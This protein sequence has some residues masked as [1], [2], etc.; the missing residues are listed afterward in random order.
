MALAAFWTHDNVT[1]LESHSSVTKTPRGWGAEFSFPESGTVNSQRFETG[2]AAAASSQVLW[3]PVV[4]FLTLWIKIASPGPIV[5]RQ[6]RVGYCGKRF[7]KARGPEGAQA[8]LRHYCPPKK[9]S[10]RDKAVFL[11]AESLGT[12]LTEVQIHLTNKE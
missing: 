9:D 6:E 7:R 11:V 12:L 1:E 5:F 4:L 3:L 10:L 8:K 2:V